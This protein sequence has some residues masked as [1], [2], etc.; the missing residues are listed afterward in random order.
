MPF[1]STIFAHAV[2]EMRCPDKT[3]L[4]PSI[5]NY[6][7]FQKFWRVKSFQNLTKI[8]EKNTKIYDIKYV[9]YKNITSKKSN[10]T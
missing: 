8:I 6:K 5:P 1:S 4:P 3:Q 9:D 2:G 7:L 10:D